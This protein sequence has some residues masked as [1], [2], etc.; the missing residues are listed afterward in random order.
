MTL[1]SSAWQE[2]WSVTSAT[3]PA[4]VTMKTFITCDTWRP[5]RTAVFISS[6]FCVKRKINII[7][8]RKNEWPV[9]CSSKISTSY[10][11]VIKSRKLWS[12][13]NNSSSVPLQ[14]RASPLKSARQIECHPF[15]SQVSQLASSDARR[16]GER[17][18]LTNP[19]LLDHRARSWPTRWFV[20]PPNAPSCRWPLRAATRKLRQFCKEEKDV[21]DEKKLFLCLRYQDISGAII[22]Y[23]FPVASSCCFD[24]LSGSWSLRKAVTRATVCFEFSFSMEMFQSSDEADAPRI[25]IPP[26]T[27][28]LCDDETIFFYDFI[29][30]VIEFWWNVTNCCTHNYS[31]VLRTIKLELEWDCVFALHTN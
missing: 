2:L 31:N 10:L 13:S 18:Q 8:E 3:F 17:P 26:L 7:R 25:F 11:S 30:F 14:A 19:L 22:P 4:C 6:Q 16:A 29:Y 27:R 28:A 21:N 1:S 24:V 9:Q 15:E 20:R 5:V 23:L 12:S